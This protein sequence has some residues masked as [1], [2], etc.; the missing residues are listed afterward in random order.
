VKAG[1][2]N[3]AEKIAESEGKG[4]SWDRTEVSVFRFGASASSSGKIA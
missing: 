1:K 2:A 3:I 4:F